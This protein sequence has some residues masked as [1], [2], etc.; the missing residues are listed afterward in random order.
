MEGQEELSVFEKSS[1]ET[2]EEKTNID[3]EKDTNAK[4][5]ACSNGL[6]SSFPRSP[7]SSPA[8]DT[9][10]LGVGNSSQATLPTD[11]N[12]A[13]MTKESLACETESVPA[14]EGPVAGGADSTGGS[15]IDDG[16]SSTSP[17]DYRAS[18]ATQENES[19]LKELVTKCSVSPDVPPAAYMTLMT[20]VFMSQV[21]K[22]QSVSKSS[23]GDAVAAGLRY[24]VEGSR[25][26]DD[27]ASKEY[28]PVDEENYSSSYPSLPNLSG[29]TFPG[30]ESFPAF[31]KSQSLPSDGLNMVSGSNSAAKMM[32]PGERQNP[33]PSTSGLDLDGFWESG[34]DANYSTGTKPSGDK[35][36]SLTTVSGNGSTDNDSAGAQSRVLA[37]INEA[38]ARTQCSANERDHEHSACAEHA[39]A[40]SGLTETGPTEK[41]DSTLML[42]S[43]RTESEKAV[44]RNGDEVTPTAVASG[45]VVPTVSSSS[46]NKA[47]PEERCQATPSCSDGRCTILDPNI[48]E[49]SPVHHPTP[50]IDYAQ[51]VANS[52]TLSSSGQGTTQPSAAI[53]SGEG[54][55]SLDNEANLV[56]SGETV[57]VAPA[58]ARASSSRR[59]PSKGVRFSTRRGS[60]RGNCTSEDI[61]HAMCMICL[62]N[63]SN[64]T[65]GGGQK[66]LGLIDSCT[67]RYCYNV[68]DLF[69]FMGRFPY[70]LMQ[71]YFVSLLDVKNLCFNYSLSC[72]LVPPVILVILT[73]YHYHAFLLSSSAFWSGARLRT[74]A[75]SVNPVSTPSRP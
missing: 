24:G 42:A 75:R 54:E 8:E 15:F 73:L 61:I 69:D 1:N 57:A 37:E 28:A 22:G 4:E 33:R 41:K 12:E 31:V 7:V 25:P 34:G 59:I 43:E 53:S 46:C 30:C 5:G 56:A 16:E 72:S 64:T 50:S 32:M 20:R 67:H 52:R 47:S 70:G 10:K 51:N 11:G 2:E 29:H 48:R 55:A 14:L 26:V 40:V 45:D 62:E 63:L 66:M 17:I 39:S 27:S 65:K 13:V 3:G 44:A 49:L 60:S 9:S 21:R 18:S 19:P 58:T 71:K 38:A 35:Q 23:E 68:S 74:D 6:N 36:R